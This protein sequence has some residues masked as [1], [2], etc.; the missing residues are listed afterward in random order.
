MIRRLTSPFGMI[1]VG[2][3]AIAALTLTWLRGTVM[4]L[5]GKPPA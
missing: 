3:V 4:E 1:F 2:F 5:A